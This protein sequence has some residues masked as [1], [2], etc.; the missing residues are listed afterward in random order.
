[1]QAALINVAN[2]YFD[3][4]WWM[5]IDQ[6]EDRFATDYLVYE[7]NAVNGSAV[8]GYRPVEI[9][10]GKGHVLHMEPH[11]KTS[12]SKLSWFLFLLNCRCHLFCDERSN[13]SISGNV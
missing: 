4:A 1:M 5:H 2:S 12:L 13:L 8:T 11:G 9:Q 10:H 7:V 3:V 6:N